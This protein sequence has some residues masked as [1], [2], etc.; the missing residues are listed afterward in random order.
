MIHN[1]T[2][3]Y[4]CVMS[5]AKLRD[6]LVLRDPSKSN[7]PQKEGSLT[8]RLDSFAEE[9]LVERWGAGVETHFQEI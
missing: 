2:Y 3:E 8:Q 5:R 4:E 9:N 6:S 1:V 7:Q